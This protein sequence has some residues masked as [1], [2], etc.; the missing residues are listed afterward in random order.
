MGDDGW[1]FQLDDNL[2][3]RRAEPGRHDAI[4]YQ[5]DGLDRL[6][7][8]GRRESDCAHLQSTMLD[9]D[10]RDKFAAVVFLTVQSPTSDILTHP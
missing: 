9:R 7:P 4:V 5:N 10:L 1:R 6:D 8:V 3:L 2:V